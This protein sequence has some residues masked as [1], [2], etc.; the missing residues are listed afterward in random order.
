MNMH[1]KHLFITVLVCTG[2]M[3][4]AQAADLRIAAAANFNSTLKKLLVLYEKQS[5]NS[6]IVSS[7]STGKLYAQIVNGAPFDIFLAA[8]A[9][10][11]ELLETAL[12]IVPG[13]RITYAK[14]RLALW[15]T[16]DIL[17]GTDGFPNINGIKYLAI[18][19]PRLAPYGVAARQTLQSLG[20]WNTVQ[21]RLVRGEST[22]QAYQF[23]A[24]GN[25][26]AGFIGASQLPANIGS[27]WLIPEHLHQPLKHQLVVLND[28]P[29]AAGFVAFLRSATASKLLQENGY[30]APGDRD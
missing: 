7:G 1:C 27:H 23:V 26:T 6:A 19:N 13:S 28:H 30:T 10:R 9:W 21:S 5:G 14:G 24:S 2:M 16:T 29:A 15:S 3:A 18:A 25:A 20:L 4:S 22:S 8:D 17:N 12:L 11:P